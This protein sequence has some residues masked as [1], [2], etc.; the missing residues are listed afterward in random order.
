[1]YN[2]KGFRRRTGS[3]G[4]NFVV[5]KDTTYRGGQGNNIFGF[6]SSQAVPT[7]LS[8]GRGKAYD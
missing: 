1:M 8:G 7:R 3:P 5:V 6:E 4:K 2:W